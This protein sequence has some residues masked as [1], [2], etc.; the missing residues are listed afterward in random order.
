MRKGQVVEAGMTAEVLANPQAPYTRLLRESV[1]RR[2]WQPQRSM[3][4]L[5]QEARDATDVGGAG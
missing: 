2:G 1:P 3:A 4:L 5:D